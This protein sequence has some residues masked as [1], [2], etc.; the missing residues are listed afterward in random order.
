MTFS[1][2]LTIFGFLANNIVKPYQIV[3]QYILSYTYNSNY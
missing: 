1:N 2:L 3:I